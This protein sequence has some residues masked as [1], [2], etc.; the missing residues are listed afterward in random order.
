MVHLAE[1]QGRQPKELYDFE[2]LRTKLNSGDRISAND[3]ERIS[4]ASHSANEHAKLDAMDVMQEVRNTERR[5]EI[6]AV[7]RVNLDSSNE[8]IQAK[9]LRLLWKSH[10]PDWKAVLSQKATSPNETIRS[11]ATTCLNRGEFVRKE[12]KR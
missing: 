1:L 2:E 9:A 3:W 7:A 5:D 6:L 4:L 11:V 12:I 8:F 10:S